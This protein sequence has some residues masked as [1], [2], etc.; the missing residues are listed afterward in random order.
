MI[1]PGRGGKDFEVNI[2][3]GAENLQHPLDF[4][5]WPPGL[6]PVLLFAEHSLKLIEMGWELMGCRMVT[7]W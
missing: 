6:E 5:S 7:H 1:L 4:N 2:F 3:L